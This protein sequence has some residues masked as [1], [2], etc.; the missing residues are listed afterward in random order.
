M[1]IY[2][3]HIQSI[4]EL[5]QVLNSSIDFYRDARAK[6]KDEKLLITINNVLA[7]KEIARDRLQ[8]LFVYE[9]LEREEKSDFLVDVRKH[10]A[11]ILSKLTSNSD[12]ILIDQLEEVEDKILKK[13]CTAIAENQKLDLV[14]E[15]EKI[16]LRMQAVH[17]KMLSLQHATA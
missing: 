9:N 17:N 16:Y 15:L 8:N 12:H 11:S 14:R 7:E 1:S 2:V 6:I 3:D 13:L 10:Y 4:R 5:I